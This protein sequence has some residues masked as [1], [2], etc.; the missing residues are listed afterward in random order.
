MIVAEE[1]HVVVWINSDVSKDRS[2]ITGSIVRNT[3][4]YDFEDN[5]MKHMNRKTFLRLSASSGAGAA[6][7]SWTN[8]QGSNLTTA[9]K[10]PFTM[11]FNPG[12]IGINAGQEKSIEMAA[13][14]GFNAVFAFTD[15]LADVPETKL[16]QLLSG[17]IQKELVWG[18]SVLPVNFRE[19]EDTFRSGL[20]KLPHWAGGLE[21]AGVTRMS[22]WIMSSHD[23]LHYL[24]NF[25]QHAT[26][27]REIAG[28][29][30]DH[31]V[32]LGLEYLG[33]RTIWASKRFPFVHSMSEAKELIAAIGHPNVGL[34]LDTSHWY[35]AGETPEDV[36]T[37]SNKDVVGCDL[38]DV[39]A[40]VSRDK[41]P[42]NHRELPGA[43]GVVDVTG[44]LEALIKIG[45]DGP[46]QAEPFNEPLNSMEDDRAARK[47]ATALKNAFSTVSL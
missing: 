2:E 24:L 28:I 4:Q 13:R 35:T 15:Y 17:M 26:R 30:K 39:L 40:G 46:I 34:H 3:N 1:I 11:E 9:G 8:T 33:P 25:R 27:L 37:L 12:T 14:Y 20:K 21:R 22:T 5:L 43:T 31:N 45:Y 7:G 29:L 19:D 32:R 10:R 36:L 18:H 41:L 38:N 42:D 23:E 16:D 47:T 6:L 44:F